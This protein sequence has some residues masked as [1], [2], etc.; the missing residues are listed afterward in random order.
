M[1]R[2]VLTYIVGVPERK[3]PV[4]QDSPVAVFTVNAVC[5]NPDKAFKT[6]HTHPGC[7][8]DSVVFFTGTNLQ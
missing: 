5:L 1:I 2:N 3:V 8:C 6:S 7:V 4:R